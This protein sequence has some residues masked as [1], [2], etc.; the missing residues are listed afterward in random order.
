M[1]DRRRRPARG[2][3]RY[4]R[5]ARLNETLR[6]VIADELVRL[7]DERLSFVTVTQI[8]VDQE[9][10]RAIVYFDSLDGPAA[11]DTIVDV[12]GEH[13]ARIQAAIA[14]QIRAKKTPIL[15]FQPDEVI[16]S[17]ERIDDILRA[18]RRRLDNRED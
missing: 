10:N 8:D 15:T 9:L 16:R 14:R 13:R 17:A 2:G 11:D 5:T 7:D 1:A 4:P 12:L 18:D 3:H 6:E